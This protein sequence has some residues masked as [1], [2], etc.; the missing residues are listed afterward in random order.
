[1][2]HLGNVLVTVSDKKIGHSTNGTTIDYY[3]ADVVSASDYYP[4]GMQMPGRSFSVGS[5]RYGF[6]GQEK[7]D[8]IDP[9]GNSMTA[10]FWQYD[11][12]IGRRWNVDP[13][14][15]DYESPYLCFGG[16][17]IWMSDAKG[18]VYIPRNGGPGPGTSTR[19]NPSVIGIKAHTTLSNVLNLRNLTENYITPTKWV[20]NSALPSGKRPDVIDEVNKKVWELKPATWQAYA[21]GKN[22]KAISQIDDYVNELNATRGGGYS[23]GGNIYQT[24]I[25]AP[26]VSADGKY[27]FTYFVPD[28]SSGI[29]YYNTLERRPNNNEAEG[30]KVNNVASSG[31]S[32]TTSS[33]V[34]TMSTSAKVI[35]MNESVRTNTRSI[36]AGGTAGSLDW[37]GLI[38]GLIMQAHYHHLDNL[39]DDQDKL[40][41]LRACGLAF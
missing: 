37:A 41:Y 36:R 39:K 30:S 31:L 9:N 10:E 5:Y 8:E 11:S 15:K 4:F 32:I 25:I 16:N 33:A 27:V 18:N 40:D 3:E 21:K 34:R 26:Q 14:R 28:P 6:N 19:D 38:V 7:S 22:N 35:P 24:P 1:M 2:N 23:A 12:R 20:T 29:I 13:V 17:P